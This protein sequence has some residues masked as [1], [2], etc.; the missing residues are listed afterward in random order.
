MNKREKNIVLTL[1][2]LLAIL[3]VYVIIRLSTSDI[4]FSII[5]SWHTTI[6][7]PDFTWTILTI[8]LILSSLLVYFIYKGIIKLLTLLWKR[9]KL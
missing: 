9:L 6:Y 1:G 2:G 4:A 8:L 7:S 5:P 3:L